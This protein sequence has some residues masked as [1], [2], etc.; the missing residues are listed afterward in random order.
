MTDEQIWLLRFGRGWVDWWELADE[1]SIDIDPIA[2]RMHNAQ[3][4]EKDTN[5]LRVRLRPK[6]ENEPIRI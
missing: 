4:L 6:E 2:E 1:T 5:S 3:M